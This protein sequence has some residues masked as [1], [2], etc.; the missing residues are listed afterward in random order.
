MVSLSTLSGIFDEKVGP[1]LEFLCLMEVSKIRFD[2]CFGKKRLPF[3]KNFPKILDFSESKLGET[4]Q[5]IQSS[6]FAIKITDYL[7]FLT[8]IIALS[9]IF[10]KN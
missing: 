2:C 7:E 1:F 5:S 4:N 6:V 10:A 8:D 9:G 3:S